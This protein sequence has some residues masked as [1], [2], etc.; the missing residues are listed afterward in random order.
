M[1]GKQAD[2]QG[3]SAKRENK[4]GTL[5]QAADL[6]TNILRRA[7][8]FLLLSGQNNQV[9]ARFPACCEETPGSG[10]DWR[11]FQT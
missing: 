11:V 4:T 8:V 1:A 2:Q 9:P 10:E 6:I 3:Q 7:Q 5:N